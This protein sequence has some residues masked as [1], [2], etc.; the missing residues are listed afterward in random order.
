MMDGDLISLEIDKWEYRQIRTKVFRIQIWRGLGQFP[1]FHKPC[2]RTFVDTFHQPS[3]ASS[4][5]P[6]EEGCEE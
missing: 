3:R 5:W 4:E 1:R 6:D 2:D